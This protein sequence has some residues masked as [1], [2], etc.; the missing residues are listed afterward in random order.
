MKLTPEQEAVVALSSGRHLVLAP[1]GS[2]KTEMLSRRII[3]AV[4]SGV[5]PARMLCATL[6]SRMSLQ[7]KWRTSWRASFAKAR[8]QARYFVRGMFAARAMRFGHI[9][10]A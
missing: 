2:G 6:S 1:P 10:T 4:K 8:R 3:G 9:L 5:D 7:R